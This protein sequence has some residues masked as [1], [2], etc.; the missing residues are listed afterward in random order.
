MKNKAFAVFAV[1]LCLKTGFNCAV[2]AEDAAPIPSKYPDYAYEY[3]G[4]DKLENFNRKMF[5]F[6][7]KLNKYAVRPVHIL[8]AS[9]MPQY[10]MDRI[11]CVTTNIEY[12]IRLVSTILQKDFKA[13][14]TETMRFF[15]NTTI[16]LGGLFDPAKSML[17][18]DAVDED[19]DQALA[20]CKVKP[21]PYLVVPI[22][23]STTPR[24]LLGRGLD[25]ALNPSSYIASPVIAIVKAGLTLN[26]SSEIQPIAIMAETTFPDP[27]DIAKKYYGLSSYIKLQN[28]DRPDVL[29]RE[30]SALYELV[31]N[32]D[33]GDEKIIVADVELPLTASKDK[34]TDSETNVANSPEGNKKDE[35]TVNE[36][37]RGG[38]NIDN[39]V[40]KSYDK[41]NSKLMADKLLFDYNPQCPV[42]DAMRT[43]LFDL[44]G[45]DD[46]IWNEISVW[47]RCFMNRIK[48]SSVNI[49]PGRENYDFKFI[50]Q[51]DKNSP[52]AIIYPSIGEGIMSYHSAVLAKLFYDEG[53]SVIIQGSHFHWEFVK[54]MPENYRP[55]MPARDADYLRSVTSKIISSL[56]HKYNCKFGDK[57][58]FGTSF[59]AVEA[60]FVAAKESQ[61]NTLGNTKFISVN[62]PVELLYAMRQIDINNESWKKNPNNLKQRVAVT[63]AKIL[64]MTKMLDNEETKITQLPFSE[65]EG[66]LITGFI[67]RQKLSDLVFSIENNSKSKKCCDFYSN[68]NNL[69]YEDY[70]EKYLA[71]GKYDDVHAL[72]YD[73]SLDSISEYLKNN[74]NYKIYHTLDDYLVNQ[75]QLKRLKQYTGRKTVLFDHGSH[76][77]FLYRKEFLDSL[78][79]DIAL[80]N[81]VAQNNVEH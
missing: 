60:L 46:S 49:F 59:G 25:T 4:N 28:L 13:S 34:L 77:G 48:T 67:M 53:Y 6:N 39:I 79:S 62:P 45:V 78:Q 29:Q 35:L 17:H 44:P 21:G 38:A 43:A 57:V 58:V 15:T 65:E 36:I 51:K 71:N 8:W 64:Q 74:D 12:P 41:K 9:V 10:G 5:A 68:V 55:G 27:Y 63:A 76:L 70:A 31:N 54:S 16:G 11:K 7:L 69:S 52:L 72:S 2:F 42:V 32:P 37:L 14:K 20:K 22:L 33:D 1:L 24:G 23:S 3:L 75:S 66:K 18:I 73:V 81:K 30:D 19:M 56:E 26:K 47:N 61:E 50:L 40:T 80:N